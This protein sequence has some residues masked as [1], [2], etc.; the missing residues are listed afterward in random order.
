MKILLKKFLCW[1]AFH[2]LLIENYVYRILCINLFCPCHPTA[3]AIV[4]PYAIRYF[5][6]SSLCSAQNTFIKPPNTWK[7]NGV[8]S[9]V[10]SSIPP[11]RYQFRPR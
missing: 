6:S 5:S 3:Q 7:L 2:S 8:P 9:V 10:G 4:P 11:R 1:L